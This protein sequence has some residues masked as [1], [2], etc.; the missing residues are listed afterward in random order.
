MYGAL[1][2]GRPRAKKL[3]SEYCMHAP[4][5]RYFDFDHVKKQM[6][7]LHKPHLDSEYI[8]RPVSLDPSTDADGKPDWTMSYI[9]GPKARAEFATFRP[10]GRWPDI[11]CLGKTCLNLHGTFSSSSSFISRTA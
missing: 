1:V 6:W 3:Y 4:Q 7:K 5:T 2:G 10:R 11:C 9:P 8:L